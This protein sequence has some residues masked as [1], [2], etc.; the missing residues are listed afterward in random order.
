MNSFWVV[1][2]E[3]SPW[4][5]WTVD[6]N[7]EGLCKGQKDE[8]SKTDICQSQMTR[9]LGSLKTI[10]SDSHH[11]T[12]LYHVPHTMMGPPGVQV[13]GCLCLCLEKLWK[14]LREGWTWKSASLWCQRKRWWAEKVVQVWK[15]SQRGLASPARSKQ[16]RLQQ[17]LARFFFHKRFLILCLAELPGYIPSPLAVGCMGVSLV[18]VYPGHHHPPWKAVSSSHWRKLYSGKAKL[19]STSSIPQLFRGAYVPIP[20]PG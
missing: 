8:S 16:R 4:E 5:R 10:Q 1:L 2:I 6:N 3:P 20:P 12:N 17:T 15:P 9:T 14:P 13:C 19:W 18:P 11:S 7:Q